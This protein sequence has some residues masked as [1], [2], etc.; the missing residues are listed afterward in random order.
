MPNEMKP[1]GQVKRG[2]AGAVVIFGLTFGT[3]AAGEW[4][5][6][7]PT[8]TVKNI[9]GGQGMCFFCGVWRPMG[10]NASSAPTRIKADRVESGDPV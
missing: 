9:P 6:E 3:V 10:R 8:E 2:L 7:F 4:P 5:L 1:F